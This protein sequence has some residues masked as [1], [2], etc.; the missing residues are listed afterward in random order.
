LM[1]AEISVQSKK[2]EGTTFILT[3]KAAEADA[4]PLTDDNLEN[5]LVSQDLQ[6]GVPELEYSLPEAIRSSKK[7]VLIVDDNKDMIEFMREILND[8]FSVFS[9]LNGAEAMKIL[10]TESI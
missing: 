2:N 6:N 10:T 7:S 1:D 8:K 5:H 9:A 3:F 4:E